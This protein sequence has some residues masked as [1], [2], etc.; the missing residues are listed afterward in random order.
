MSASGSA[1]V[2]RNANAVNPF[3]LAEL[4][5]IVGPSLDN[6]SL[7]NLLKRADGV[8][9]KAVNFYFDNERIRTLAHS[10]Y[11][12]ESKAVCSQKLNKVLNVQAQEP[13]ECE[14][15]GGTKRCSE[16]ESQ[17]TSPKMESVNASDESKWPKYLG[18]TNV[19]AY[20]TVDLGAEKMPGQTQVTVCRRISS[21]G[22]DAQ[23]VSSKKANKSGI[24]SAR[25]VDKRD[26][27][28]R[29]RIGDE[30]S[31]ECGRL[32][33]EVSKPLAIL[34]D[35]G[36]IEVDGCTL[37]A[38]DS[39]KKFAN[40]PM[41]LKIR[42]NCFSVTAAS[43]ETDSASHAPHEAMIRLLE[44]LRY[45]PRI[46]SEVQISSESAAEIDFAISHEC[47]KQVDASPHTLASDETDDKTDVDGEGGELS[48][49]HV[50][51][52]F[53]EADKLNWKLPEEP[54]PASMQTV[55]RDYQRQVNLR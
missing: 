28:L 7:A 5:S 51:I 6:A 22:R 26:Y 40:V 47:P 44:I 52:L 43:N 31:R 11:A 29:W 4:R 34:L 38:P 15:L 17:Q 13:T 50:D 32:P 30:D 20:T 25:R 14:G 12:P 24:G 48:K 53:N 46:P 21:A 37:C 42:M 33:S 35:A 55:L 27:I 18:T 19:M 45:V 39:S 41:A 1:S 9:E 2:K 23:V 36:W 3:R 8:I 16:M 49:E 54:Q 10:A